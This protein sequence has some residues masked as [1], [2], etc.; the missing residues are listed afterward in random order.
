MDKA[1]APR[2]RWKGKNKWT[3]LET[4]FPMA[5]LIP[6]LWIDKQRSYYEMNVYLV[7]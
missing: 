6:D 5:V 2:E 1:L 3:L 4:V 7:Y